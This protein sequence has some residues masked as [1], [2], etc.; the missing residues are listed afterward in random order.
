MK[1]QIHMCKSTYVLLSIYSI[2]QLYIS[3]SNVISL[4]LLCVFNY[5][6]Y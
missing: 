3:A 5:F 4:C 6:I 1:T 2:I